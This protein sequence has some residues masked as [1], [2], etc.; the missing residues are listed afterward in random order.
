MQEAVRWPFG[1]YPP[2]FST[3]ALVLA[4]AGLLAPDPI[5][6]DTIR[7]D[8]TALLVSFLIVLVMIAV[9]AA[10]AF[11]ALTGSDSVVP[12]GGKV[13]VFGIGAVT[14]S[15]LLKVLLPQ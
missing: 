3:L 14:L 1:V 5:G 12:L 2:R 8:L 13:I 9:N 7:P 15:I 4:L 10:E 11:E 6:A